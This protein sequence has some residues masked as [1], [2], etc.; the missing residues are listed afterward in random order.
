VLVLAVLP[1]VGVA[2]PRALGIDRVIAVV[3]REAI[4]YSEL[5]VKVEQARQ[6]DP[7]PGYDHSCDIIEDLLYEKLLV[8]QG[9]LDS[10][11][12]DEGQVNAELD[13]RIR[14]FSQQLGGDKKLEEYYGKSVAE[15]KADFKGQ[16]KDQ[17]LVQQMQQ[18]ITSDLS[19]TP[20]EVKR[21]YD[22]IPEDSIPLIGAEVEYSMILRLPKPTEDEERRV[23]RKMEEFREAVSK[24]EKDFCTV[25][26]LYSEDPGSASN[27]GELGLVP[28]GAMV[29]AFDAV[30]ASLKE[31]EVSQVFKT[32]YGWHFM[33]MIERRGEQYNARHVLMRPQVAAADLQRARTFL[34]SI[35]RMVVN[36]DLTFNKA[37]GEFSDD[38]ESRGMNGMMIEPNSNTA[39]WDLSALD[40]QTFFVLD[41]LKIGEIS[42]PQ[43]LV[44]PDGTKA[45]RLLQLANRTEPHR[46]NLRVDY[47]LIQQAC[48]GRHRSEMIDKWI[49][50]HISSTYVRLDEAYST[51]SFTHPWIST[52]DQ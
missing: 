32:E 29:P 47:R 43:L 42:E 39:R 28:P 17:L 8:E 2:Q 36:E 41:K 18:K 46:A 31:G 9:K 16:V 30:A 21:F 25:A 1:L 44:M 49:T 3:G 50:A 20:R 37:A 4:L 35:R 11:V 38:E 23:R 13:R 52:A 27:C 51:C 10:V 15:I 14:Y 33:Q 12:V 26:I 24:G 6:A 45:Y 48:E 40:Q 5:V 19:I 7:R 34:D 22:R